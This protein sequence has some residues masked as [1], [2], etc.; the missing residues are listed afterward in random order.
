MILSKFLKLKLIHPPQWLE[1][2]IHFLTMAG[3][4]SYGTA[5]NESDIDMFGFCT[6]RKETIF[7]HL[8]G[9]I[10]NFGTPPER[11][12]RWNEVHI[13]DPDDGREYDFNVLNIVNFF[14]LCRKNN[15][16]ITDVL[17]AP[18]ECIVHIT[19]TGELVRENRHKF[20]SKQVFWRYKG[21][22]YSQLNK[23]E[24][25]D[26]IGKRKVLRDKFGFDPKFMS[27]LYRLI[28]ECEQI[29]TEGD[30]DLRRNHEQVKWVK[31]GNVS[32]EEA[33]KWFA[34]KEK[35]LEELLLKTKLPDYPDEE[36]LKTLLLECLETHYG[37]LEKAITLPNNDKKLLIEFKKLA[38]KIPY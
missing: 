13:I 11:F 10:N 3:S 18:R 30:L 24:K 35:Q 1:S 9:H 15:P 31:E 23:S 4:H 32:I 20:L 38:Q 7:P 28:L 37:S 16:D 21:Y 5:T 33:K 19:K 26:A 14:E 25:E 36:E 17:F 12:D 22:A 8:A 34:S 6:P 2:N 27:H 29:L